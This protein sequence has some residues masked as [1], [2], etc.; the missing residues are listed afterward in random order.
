MPAA[1]K[2]CEYEGG[3]NVWGNASISDTQ[4]RIQYVANERW[5]I[6]HQGLYEWVR[7]GRNG[8]VWK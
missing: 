1:K 5:M 3:E 8:S 7:E 2:F 6:E 4:G